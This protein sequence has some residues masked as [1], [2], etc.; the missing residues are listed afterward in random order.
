MFAVGLALGYALGRLRAW[1]R[2]ALVVRCARLTAERDAYRRACEWAIRKFANDLE[3]VSPLPPF[4]DDLTDP[5]H[6]RVLG[7]EELTDAMLT[8][9]DPDDA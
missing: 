4:V 8:W 7:P 6:V 3:Y 1:H 9:E 2:D 5:W